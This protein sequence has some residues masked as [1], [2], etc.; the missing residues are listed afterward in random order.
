MAT[1]LQ[2]TRKQLNYLLEE[3]QENSLQQELIHQEMNE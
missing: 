2:Y 3:S 1:E